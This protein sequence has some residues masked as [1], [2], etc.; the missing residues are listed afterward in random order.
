[1]R[2]PRGRLG[3]PRYAISPR[4]G[5]EPGLVRKRR[6]CL[7]TVTGVA[8]DNPA[9][10]L[11]GDADFVVQQHVGRAAVNIDQDNIADPGI[12]TVEHDLGGAVR[13][14]VSG[15]KYSTSISL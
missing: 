12:H 5:P 8:V 6:E 10:R 2:L 9:D 11:I 15:S 7:L 13:L 4:R 1:M 14:R 3:Q